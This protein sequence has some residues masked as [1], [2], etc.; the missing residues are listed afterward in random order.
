[1]DKLEH[2]FELQKGLQ[3]KLKTERKLD[4]NTLKKKKK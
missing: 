3:T 2:I 1:M 4:F